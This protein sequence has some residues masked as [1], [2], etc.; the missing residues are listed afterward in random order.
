MRDRLIAHV[1]KL[2]TSLLVALSLGFVAIGV[3]IV[4]IEEIAAIIAFGWGAILLFSGFAVIGIRQLFRDGLVMEIDARGILWRRW[5]DQ[6]IPWSAIT[7]A[8]PRA[9]RGQQFLCLWLDAPERYPARSTLG[10][11][12]SLNKGMGF[13]DIALAVQG[14]DQSFQRLLEVVGNHLHALDD[15]RVGT[16]SAPE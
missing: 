16:G 10:W 13:G 5:S 7:R 14:T 6:V 11:L 12:A 15:H 1:S 4:R 8:E 3:W 2:K 9:I